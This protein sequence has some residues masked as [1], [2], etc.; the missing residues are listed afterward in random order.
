LR[1]LFA[2]ISTFTIC[3]MG[4]ATVCCRSCYYGS[5]FLFGEKF[6]LIFDFVPR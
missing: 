6:R 2:F 4:H 3:L 5:C 1:I